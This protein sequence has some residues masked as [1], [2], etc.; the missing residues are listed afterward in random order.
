MSVDLQQTAI[1]TDPNSVNYSGDEYVAMLEDLQGN[2][3]KSHGR[4]FTTHLLIEFD[5]SNVAGVKDWIANVV[6]PMVTA[7][8]A[9]H[10]AAEAFRANGVDAGLFA[11]FGLSAD[12]YRALGIADIPDDPSFLRGLKNPAQG[13]LPLN[14]PPVSTWEPGFQGPIHA[15]LLLADDDKPTLDAAVQQVELEL[16]G[17]AQVVDLEQGEVLRNASGEPI[18]PF[19]FADGVSQPLF[20]VADIEAARLNGGIDRY[21]PSAPLGLVLREDLGGGPSGYGSYFVYR[22]L[23]QDVASFKKQE[24]ELAAALN[25]APGDELAG[26]YVVGRFRDG[27]PVVAQPVG[28]WVNEPLNFNYDNDVDGVRCPF[29]AHIRK[30]NPRGDKVREFGLPAGE[31]RSRRIARRAVPYPPG[32]T[33]G[34]PPAEGTDVGLLFICAQSSIVHQFE[35][36]QSIWS[37]FT[38][39]LR[40]ETGLDPVIGQGKP[41]A[42][43]VP[44]SWPTDWGVRRAAPVQFDFSTWVTLRGGEYFFLPSLSFLKGLSGGN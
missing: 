20:L 11:N 3:V 13:P 42:A 26:A 23:A 10:Q 37:N 36:I 6:A 21:D 29:H 31:D 27:T 33:A 24:T 25:L 16:G 17:I 1:D 35:F 4:E 19:G 34:A 30:A 2:I 22:K 9:Q 39:F 28:G 8:L 44:Q 12:G 18:E 14:D 38:D 7:A 15:L 5:G 32:A 40:P 43:P 41:G